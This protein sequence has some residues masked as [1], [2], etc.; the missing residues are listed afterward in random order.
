MAIIIFEGNECCFKTTAAKCLQA[1]LPGFIYIKGS[2]F[3]SASHGNEALFKHY[4]TIFKRSVD[5]DLIV[6]RFFISNLVYASLPEGAGY[7]MLTDAQVQYFVGGLIK[8]RAIFIHMH[9]WASWEII[10]RLQARGDDHYANAT[11]EQI[12]HITSLY[13]RTIADYNI[14]VSYEFNCSG[15]ENLLS[16]LGRI[17]SEQHLKTLS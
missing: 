15:T 14:P 7:S 16:F 4:D 3:A 6:D 1:A 13:S 2:D 5:E 10:N 12:S 11:E 8:Y 17:I 9:D